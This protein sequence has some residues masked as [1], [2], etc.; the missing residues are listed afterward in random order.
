M[1]ISAEA[2]ELGTWSNLTLSA[3]RRAATYLGDSFQ[4]SG[5]KSLE[6]VEKN[7]VVWGTRGARHSTYGSITGVLHQGCGR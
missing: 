7:E 3:H 5:C 4:P 2:D 6:P 1:D